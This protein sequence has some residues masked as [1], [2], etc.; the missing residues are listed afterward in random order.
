MGG[1]GYNSQPRGGRQGSYRGGSNRGGY[2]GGSR[3]Q[4]PGRM[5]GAPN[6]QS[7]MMPSQNFN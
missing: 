2:T 6:M 5:G 4:Q 7:P 1:Q 3:P